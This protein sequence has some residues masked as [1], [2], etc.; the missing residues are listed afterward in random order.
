MGWGKLS[1]SLRTLVRTPACARESPGNFLGPKS[2]FMFAVFAF[3]ITND[4]E[5]D[6]M[7]VSV[8]EGKLTGF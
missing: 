1:R 6:T 8:N 4:L 5:N 3:K 7:T 2:C